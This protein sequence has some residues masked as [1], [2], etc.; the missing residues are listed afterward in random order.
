MFSLARSFFQS[1]AVNHPAEWNNS[2]H[3]PVRP[4]CKEIVHGT[5][6][7]AS[8]ECTAAVNHP[9]L[10][11]QGSSHCCRPRSPCLRVQLV[12]KL[13]EAS[14]SRITASCMSHSCMGKAGEGGIVCRLQQQGGRACV[15]V[16]GGAA[17]CKDMP[18]ATGKKL[19][20]GCAALPLCITCYPSCQY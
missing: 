6:A 10:P 18:K 5:C 4:A 8:R 3:A 9:R 16:K 13:T 17:A 19:R 12:K 14:I 11:Q 2:D 7:E 20:P 1:V 15:I